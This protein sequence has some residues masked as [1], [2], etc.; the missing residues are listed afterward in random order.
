MGSV[1]TINAG[2]NSVTV[3]GPN[4]VWRLDKEPDSRESPAGPET[5]VICPLTFCPIG[6]CSGGPHVLEPGLGAETSNSY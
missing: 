1:S 6:Q 2:K 4:S 3:S 5:P